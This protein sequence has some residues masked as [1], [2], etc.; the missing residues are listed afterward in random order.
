MNH[1][2]AVGVGLGI[3]IV[4]VLIFALIVGA[5]MVVSYWKLFYKAGRPGWPAIVPVY[6]VIEMLKM[7]KLSPYYAFILIGAFIPFIGTWVGLGFNIFISIFIAKAFGK[8]PGFTVGLILLPIVFY[9]ILAFGDSKYQLEDEPQQ[10]TE[11]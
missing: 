1:Y 11:A 7:C 8:T 4:V 2:E 10:V 6:N 9:P 3:A 5:I